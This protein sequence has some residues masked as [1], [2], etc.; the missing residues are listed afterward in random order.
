MEARMRRC[1]YLFFLVLFILST[2]LVYSQTQSSKPQTTRCAYIQQAEYGVLYADKQHPDRYHLEL[3][4]VD[5]DAIYVSD[6]IDESN[7]RAKD[8]DIAVLENGDETLV[9]SLS[10]PKQVKE[11]E[12]VIYLAQLVSYGGTDVLPKGM[13]VFHNVSVIY[14]PNGSCLGCCDGC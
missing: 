1:F 14:E 2:P 12:S 7:P 9:L 8:K 5:P 3:V 4:N 13:N 11:H 10:H 6:L